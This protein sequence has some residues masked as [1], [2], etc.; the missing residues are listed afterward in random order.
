MTGFRTD[1]PGAGQ[2]WLLTSKAH[3][4]VFPKYLVL[5]K[6]AAPRMLNTPEVGKGDFLVSLL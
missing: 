2:A 3:L 1:G 6:A 4:L 5:Y